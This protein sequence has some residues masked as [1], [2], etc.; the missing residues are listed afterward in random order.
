MCKPLVPHKWADVIKAWADGAA[1][2]WK[3]PRGN[4]IDMGNTG[5]SPPFVVDYEWRV[6]PIPITKEQ[7]REALHQML[8]KRP[9]SQ[10]YG[11][12]WDFLHQDD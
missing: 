10:E 9:F 12:I 11:I 4:W 7:A 2:Q 5:S 1:V 6:K 3:M 8:K